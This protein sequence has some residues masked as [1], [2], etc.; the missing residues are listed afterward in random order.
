VTAG[1][2]APGRRLAV[3]GWPIE[4]SLSPVL[5]AAAARE[6]GADW[7]Y[8][9]RPVRE[10]ELAG[11]VD[12]LDGAWLGLSVTAPLKREAARIAARLDDRAR[13]TG[14]ANTLLL[15]AQ[16]RGWNT[17]VGGIVRAFA[18]AGLDGAATGAIVGAG[19]TAGSA[20]VALA[21]LGARHVVVA[22]RTPA[23]GGELAALGERLGVAVALQPLH[24][25]V[26]AVDAAVSTL[27]AAAEAAPA[28]AHPP[29]RLLDADYARAAG[30]R[31]R[32]ALPAAALID[33]REMLLGQA[34]LQARIFASGDAAA[35][36]PDEERVAGAMRSALRAA[37]RLEES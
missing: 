24:A 5:H 26:P 4:H 17:D 10:G 11:F 31:Y 27:P 7:R 37:T 16:P 6:L 21:E 36:L 19:A 30:S 13:L 20:L 1:E 8:E 28:F 29:S 25:P 23:K 33:G 18:E 12:V 14:A 32:D 2:R 35:P 3:V 15:G 22:L 9:R 34:V